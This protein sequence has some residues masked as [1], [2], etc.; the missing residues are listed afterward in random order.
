MTFNEKKVE[1]DNS[2]YSVVKDDKMLITLKKK[3]C[4]GVLETGERDNDNEI[5]L[6]EEGGIEMSIYC[7][8]HITRCQLQ[9]FSIYAIARSLF[10][11]K[12]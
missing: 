7:A 12:Y 11:L 2:V 6:K 3:T 1:F 4:L 9:W 5:S 8:F 10:A